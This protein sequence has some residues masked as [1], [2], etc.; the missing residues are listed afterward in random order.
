MTLDRE[1]KCHWIKLWVTLIFEGWNQ[2]RNQQKSLRLGVLPFWII[3]SLAC[4][5]FCVLAHVCLIYYHF[6]HYLQFSKTH[7]AFSPCCF[8]VF[9][10]IF[11]KHYFFPTFSR[12][13]LPLYLL[14]FT[15][16][17]TSLVV[18]QTWVSFSFCLITQY[19]ARTQ[20]HTSLSTLSC[21][22]CFS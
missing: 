10:H 4:E 14:G 17:V 2:R 3:S 6:S 11:W 13:C 16:G 12:I 9:L 19:T 22:H 21:S 5:V 18:C 7:H 20:H 1:E 15:S 8:Y